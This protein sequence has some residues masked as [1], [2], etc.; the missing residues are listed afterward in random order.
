M[1]TP[2]WIKPAIMGAVVGAIGLAVVGFTGAG[3]MTASK[4][5]VAAS[6]RASIDVTAALL[7][8][9][10]SQAEADPKFGA[11]METFKSKSSYQQTEVVE[12]AGWATM[13]G[14]NNPNNRVARACAKK[15]AS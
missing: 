9:C 14:S 6:D 8:I 3:W 13:P 7:P 12:E 4:A 2:Q 15:L 5:A 11:K 10:T 1:S